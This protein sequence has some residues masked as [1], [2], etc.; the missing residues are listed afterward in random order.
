MH[1]PVLLIHSQDDPVTPSASFMQST[2]NEYSNI[3]T[4]FPQHGGHGGFFTFKKRYGD[5]DGFWAQ[6][7]AMEFIRLLDA[8]DKRLA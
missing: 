2:I 3:I 7:R 1:V 5:L 4:L 6:N 8:Q